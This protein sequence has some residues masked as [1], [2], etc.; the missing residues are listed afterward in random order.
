[1]AKP[2]VTIVWP[3]LSDVRLAFRSN[4]RKFM[5]AALGPDDPSTAE[6]EAEAFVLAESWGRDPLR[7]PPPGWVLSDLE[8]E[9]VA[10]VH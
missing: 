7:P 6:A 1:M 3:S 2:W 10:G 8:A 9:A 4:G 5:V